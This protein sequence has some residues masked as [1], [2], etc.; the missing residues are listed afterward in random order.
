MVTASLVAS[1]VAASAWVQ[2]PVQPVPITLQV[3]FVVL[4][5]LLLAPEWAFGSMAV[6]LGLGAIGVPV[7]SGGH[8]GIGVLAGPTGG[9]LYGFIAAAGLG[10]SV[11]VLLSGTRMNALIVDAVSAT[12]VI[13]VIYTVGAAHLAMV[14]GL[15]APK[16]I[17]AGVAPFI[18]PD[19]LKAAAA[20]IVAAAVRRAVR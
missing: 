20:V 9:Y 10:S 15:S 16:A 8:G 18:V 12:V 1:L 19:G 11:R 13:L 3:F 7:F 17:A 5:A 2:I 14:L 4:A 6:Y